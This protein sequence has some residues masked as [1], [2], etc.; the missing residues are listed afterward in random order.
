L[1]GSPETRDDGREKRQRRRRPG[2]G[3][4]RHALVFFFTGFVIF[5]IGSTWLGLYPP[6]PIDLGGLPNLD[7]RAER[8]SIP[9]GEDD[10]LDAWLVPGR[11]PALVILL[12]GYGRDHTSMWCYAHFLH[13]AGYSVLAADFRS[14][15]VRNRKPTTLGFW[16]QNDARA[17]LAW[18]AR[19]PGLRED[20]I[21][22]MGESLGGSVALSIAPSHPEVRALVVDSP[23]ATGH[24]A[25]SDGA[26][27]FFHVAREPFA[28]LARFA[29]LAITHHDP[30]ALNCIAACESLTTRPL[31]LIHSLRDDRLSPDQSRDLWRATGSNAT[32]W[33]V[34]VAGH[35]QAWV[36]YR[37]EYERRVLAFLAGPLGSG[38]RR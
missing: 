17:I 23:F 29:T 13:D 22:I 36:R 11:R 32:L 26:E 3:G 38:A 19:Q 34:P 9:V 6:V 20:R 27:R 12:H 33:V 37:G 21:G 10:H 1:G 31:F 2:Q 18:V 5:V 8:V 24:R 30:Y 35:T 7:S 16:E 4:L 28:A 15:R 25:L 14:S